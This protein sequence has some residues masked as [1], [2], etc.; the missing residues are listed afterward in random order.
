[1]TVSG[2]PSAKHAWDALNAAF[3]SQT[4]AR[5]T[6]LTMELTSIHKKAE[7]DLMMYTSRAKAMQ[8]ELASA[9]QPLD[10]NTV[11][12]YV[13]LG[14]PENFKMIKTV[15]LAAP[16]F[17][18][19]ESV[20][21]ALL[22]IEAEL[23][24]ATTKEEGVTAAAYQASQART[25]ARRE[26]RRNIVCWNCNKRGNYQ[27]ECRSARAEEN[28]EGNAPDTKAVVFMATGIMATAGVANAHGDVQTHEAHPGT[29]L[30]AS[31]MDQGVIDTRVYLDSGASH[32][33]VNNKDAFLNYQVVEDMHVVLANG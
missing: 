26:R 31:A 20:L 1:V 19:W 3:S 10:E 27:S 8:A 18:S 30:V 22:P 6:Q 32:H 13:L 15:L 12:L 29:A 9:G 17:L 2:S 24:E 11:I 7:E 4:N 5:R 16:Q 23:G 21:A 28:K 25:D 14:L 33:M